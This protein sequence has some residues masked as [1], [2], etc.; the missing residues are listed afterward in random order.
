MLLLAANFDG[1]RQEAHGG[2][3]AIRLAV[4]NALERGAAFSEVVEA[5][6]ISAR[7]ACSGEEPIPKG[8]AGIE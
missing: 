5:A 8:T 2:L 7:R 4:T 3:A 6:E 1:P